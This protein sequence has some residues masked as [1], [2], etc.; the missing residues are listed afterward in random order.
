MVVIATSCA[1]L[2]FL[3][4]A[5]SVHGCGRSGSSDSDSE[6]VLKCSGTSSEYVKGLERSSRGN[7]DSILLI[8]EAVCSNAPSPYRRDHTQIFFADWEHSFDRNYNWNTCPDG[9][10]VQG[11]YWTGGE[12]LG[13]I[14]DG[15]CM[16]PASHPYHYGHCYDKD[17]SVS[18]NYRGVSECR[19]DYFVTGLY[20]GSCDQLYCI[21]KMRCCNMAPRPDTINS[22]SQAKIRVM[23]NTMSDIA[24]LAH[25][26]GYGWCASCR[27]PYVGEDFRRQGDTWQADT[28]EPCSGA[29]SHH[30]LSMNYGHWKFSIKNMTFGTPVLQSLQPETVDTGVVNNELPYDVTRVITRSAD[31]IRSVTHTAT[32]EWRR[33]HELGLTFGYSSV[34]FSSSAEYRF[35]YGTSTTTSDS[36]GRTQAGSFTVK[37]SLTVPAYSAANFTIIISQTRRTVS[38]TATILI[39]FST[40]LGGFMRWG[41]GPDGRLTN[42]HYQHKG[43]ERRPTVHYRFGNA[44]VPFYE[45]LKEESDSLQRPWLWADM[46]QR[47]TYGQNVINRLTREGRY[48]FTLTGKF[49]DVAGN[50]VQIQW[51]EPYPMLGRHKRSAHAHATGSARVSDKAPHKVVIHDA[52]V[53]VKKVV[54]TEKPG[55]PPSEFPPPPVVALDPD[56]VVDPPKEISSD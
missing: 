23:D 3:L 31:V 5:S 21:E 1:C 9:Y 15:R 41:R 13:N 33:S 40:E 16:K 48:E 11:F 38:Y 2:M 55:D 39:H 52:E 50:D 37:E 36:T 14:R 46:K 51:G 54:A 17:V 12:R 20:R 24:T 45:A 25:Y 22:L 26:L 56:S 4:Y 28:T 8:E 47:Y 49:D 44:R 53:E 7:P 32:S 6:G 29:L 18:F 34:G 19:D 42:C 10:F 27:A 43:S 30:R 35:T